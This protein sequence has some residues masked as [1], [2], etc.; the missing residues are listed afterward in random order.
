MVVRIGDAWGSKKKMGTTVHIILD[1]K[2]SQEEFTGAAEKR[3]KFLDKNN[4]GFIDQKEWNDIKDSVNKRNS[5]VSPLIIFS[6]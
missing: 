2:I 5:K 4:D 6:F 3:F 1:G